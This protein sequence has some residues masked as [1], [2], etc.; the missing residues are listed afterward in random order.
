M[1]PKKVGTLN[2]VITLLLRVWVR[3]ACP[4]RNYGA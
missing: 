3:G 2:I 4:S 1:Q